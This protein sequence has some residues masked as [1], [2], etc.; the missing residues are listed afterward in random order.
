MVF[1]EELNILTARIAAAAQSREVIDVQDLMYR[2]TLDSFGRI[3][4]GVQLGC[5]SCQEQVPFAEA[6]DKMQMVRL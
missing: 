5:L 2:F 3:G 6:F 4:F 1:A